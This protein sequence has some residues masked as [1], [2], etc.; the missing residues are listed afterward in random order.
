MSER[1]A[2]EIG[3]YIVDKFQYMVDNKELLRSLPDTYDRAVPSQ[4]IYKAFQ[5]SLKCEREKYL[6]TLIKELS[7]IYAT[8]IEIQ[9]KYNETKTTPC[10]DV[11]KIVDENNELKNMCADLEKQCQLADNE[12]IKIE[13]TQK[14]KLDEKKLKLNSFNKTIETIQ[15]TQQMINNQVDQFKSS[16]LKTTAVTKK[17]FNQSRLWCYEQAEKCAEMNHDHI[18]DSHQNKIDQLNDKIAAEKMERRRLEKLCQN[19]LNSIESISD[20]K[21]RINIPIS[22]LPSEIGR[23]KQYI[24]RNIKKCKQNAIQTL[25]SEIA[26]SIPGI[27]VQSGNIMTAVN[28]ALEDRVRQKEI[29]CQRVIRKAEESERRLQAELDDVLSRIKKY[30]SA[31]SMNLDIISEIEKTKMDWNESKKALDEKMNM[32]SS[33]V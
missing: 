19:T 12:Y 20:G 6:R 9:S 11:P 32:L 31:Q 18:L 22:D 23:V 5:D 28:K 13:K 16:Y 10:I 24:E 27:E 8:C 30:Q 33:S 3:Q 1:R 4:L 17:M 29:E 14:A 21:E 15:T 25:R 26:T 2:E 7:D